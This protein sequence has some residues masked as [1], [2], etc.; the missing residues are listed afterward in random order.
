MW[1]KG[2]YFVG[3]GALLVQNKVLAMMGLGA[4]SVATATAVAS[5]TW[6]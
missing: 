4:A 2:R 3:I 1:G 5:T 6:W